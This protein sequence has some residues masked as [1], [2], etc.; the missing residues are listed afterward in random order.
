[1]KY[2]AVWFLVILA[3][4]VLVWFASDPMWTLLGWWWFLVVIAEGALVGS[5]LGTALAN[6]EAGDI[7]KRLGR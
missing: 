7:E 4:C 5:V 3:N 2:A 1:M 6:W